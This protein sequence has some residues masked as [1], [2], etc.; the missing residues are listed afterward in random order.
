MSE[1]SINKTIYILT[2]K[3][4][5]TYETIKDLD[6]EWLIQYTDFVVSQLQHEAQEANTASK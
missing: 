6:F 3:G 2:N 4:Q 1:E 5:L